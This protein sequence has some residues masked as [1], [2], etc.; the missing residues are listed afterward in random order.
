MLKPLVSKLGV[1][2]RIAFEGRVS[3]ERLAELYAT[4]DVF[5]FPSQQ[6]GF[7]IVLLEAMFCGLPVVASRVSA[8]PELV[9]DSQEGFLFPPGDS[10]A[11]ATAMRRL[12]AD[13]VLRRQLASHGKARTKD[14][15]W[16]RSKKRFYGAVEEFL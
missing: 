12:M 1:D 4:C 16:E 2:Q 3:T 14:F 5:V 9:R 7:G 15:C 11:L 10:A 13:P 8:I 6:E